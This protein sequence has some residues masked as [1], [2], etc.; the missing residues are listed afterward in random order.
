VQISFTECWLLIGRWGN[1]A[2]RS[3]VYGNF[4]EVQNGP[5]SVSDSV[6]ETISEPLSAENS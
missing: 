2:L 3:T 5:E 4:F 6:S 1:S